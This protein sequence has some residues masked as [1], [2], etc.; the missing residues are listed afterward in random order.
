LQPSLEAERACATELL[1]ELTPTSGHGRAAGGRGHENVGLGRLHDGAQ[2]AR[3]GDHRLLVLDGGR[4]DDLAVPGTVTALALE[5]RK[6]L[7]V[8]VG[9]VARPI[10]CPSVLSF[11]TQ[12]RKA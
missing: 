6:G 11:L 1:S 7:R 2:V 8:G 12:T 5:L 4:F 3:T 10:S 9:H